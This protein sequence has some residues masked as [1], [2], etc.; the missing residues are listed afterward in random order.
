MLIVQL[1]VISFH[2]IH[3]SMFPADSVVQ[4]LIT[5]VNDQ[6]NTQV[7]WLSFMQSEMLML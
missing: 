1:V 3:H 2:K 4:E 6:V 5:T 7:H